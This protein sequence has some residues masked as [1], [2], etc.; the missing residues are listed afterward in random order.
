VYQKSTIR[1]ITMDARLDYNGTEI[2]MTPMRPRTG[3]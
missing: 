3:P 2:G 1:E